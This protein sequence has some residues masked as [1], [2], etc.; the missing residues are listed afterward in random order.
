[1]PF[2]GAVES[3]DTDW[4]LDSAGGGRVCA[5][6]QFNQWRDCSLRGFSDSVGNVLGQLAIVL[7][8]GVAR[9]E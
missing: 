3:L 2:R 9:V 8:K 6:R 4:G 7:V 5:V 1:M